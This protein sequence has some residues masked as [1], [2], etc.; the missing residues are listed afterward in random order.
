MSRKLQITLED[1][2]YD[3]LQE[4]ARRTRISMAE[5]IRMLIDKE[6]RPGARPNL[7]GFTV[8]FTRRPDEPFLG[9]RPGIKFS[10]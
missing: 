8:A 10:N 9:R 2:Q 1:D 3:L 7:G 4:L 5:H 6:H